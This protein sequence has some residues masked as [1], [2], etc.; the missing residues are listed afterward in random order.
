MILKA[1]TFTFLILLLLLSITGFFV[2]KDIKDF[3]NN[4][5]E[6]PVLFVLTD[7]NKVLTAISME[8]LEL[9]EGFFDKI[10]E[11]TSPEEIEKLSSYYQ[12][13]DYSSMLNNNYKLVLTDIRFIENGLKDS[14]VI[15][16]K[17]ELGKGLT[18]KEII[19]VLKAE[20]PLKISDFEETN[21]DKIRNF[22]FIFSFATIIKENGPFFMIKE[23]K[24]NNIEIYKE[25]FS[26]KLIKNIPKTKN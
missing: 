13:K 23:M 16:D 26:L 6:K 18:K 25:P 15:G 4:I 10:S 11:A 12:N 19:D 9:E 22:F 20:N 3:Q 24:N 2:Y 17:S 5:G 8:K 1:I 14:F 21:P 7:Q